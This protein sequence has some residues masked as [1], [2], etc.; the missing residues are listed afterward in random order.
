MI[1]LYVYKNGTKVRK[2]FNMNK[3]KVCFCITNLFFI[4]SYELCEGS[5]PK[6]GQNRGFVPNICHSCNKDINLLIYRM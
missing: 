6:L 4:I 2:N 1:Y 3:K 5:A